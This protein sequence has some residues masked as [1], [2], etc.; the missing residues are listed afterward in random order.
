MANVCQ[1]YD[2]M[3]SE[4]QAAGKRVPFSERILVFN[5]VKVGLKVHY[6]ASLRPAS[7]LDLQ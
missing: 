2:K 5:E 6:H 4:K 3:V 1:Q 7:L